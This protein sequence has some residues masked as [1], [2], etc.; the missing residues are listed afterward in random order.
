MRTDP[1]GRQ[2]APAAEVGGG[3]PA[4]AGAVEVLVRVHVWQT[5]RALRFEYDAPLLS[6]I[7]P[8]VVPTS[9]GELLLD[10]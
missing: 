2:V 9:G 4:G 7:T 3:A 10:G 1:L 8:A 6:G 5:T